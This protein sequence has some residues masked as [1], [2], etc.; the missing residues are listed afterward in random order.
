MENESVIESNE[1]H[2]RE[3][4]TFFGLAKESLKGRWVEA[5]IVSVLLG[6]IIGSSSLFGFSILLVGPISL[7][8]SIWSLRFVRQ[9]DSRYEDLFEGFQHFGNAFLLS[10]LQGL[11]VFG[12]TLLLIIPGIIASL[13]LSQ[14]FFI[15]ADNPDMKP[16]EV[17]RESNEMMKGHKGELFGILILFFLMSLACIFTLGIGFFFLMPYMRTTLTHF[18]LNLVWDEEEDEEMDTFSL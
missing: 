12:L 15:L 17:I 6:L 1:W 9:E 11:I 5:I 3:N 18:Y 13:A 8:A 14:S 2:L 4:E 16:M 10:L 7:G